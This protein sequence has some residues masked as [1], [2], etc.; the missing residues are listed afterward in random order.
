M[1]NVIDLFTKKPKTSDDKR[2][3]SEA[4][5]HLTKEE[6]LHSMVDFQEERSREGRLTPDLIERGIPLFTI[7]EQEAETEELKILTR[8]YRAYLEFE[9]AELNRGVK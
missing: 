8:A 7:L 5:S 9:Q 6:L 2:N 1:S 4:Y 3:W